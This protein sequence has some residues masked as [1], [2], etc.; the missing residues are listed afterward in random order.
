MDN[1]GALLEA[2]KNGLGRSMA[3]S[4]GNHSGG[5]VDGQLPTKGTQWLVGS[6]IALS[7]SITSKW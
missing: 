1:S 2:G 4:K 5:D 7:L 6:V 3:P